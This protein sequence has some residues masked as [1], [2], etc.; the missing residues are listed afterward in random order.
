MINIDY[1][2]GSRMCQSNPTLLQHS[3]V[4]QHSLTVVYVRM[5]VGMYVCVGGCVFVLA[6]VCAGLNEG[7]ICGS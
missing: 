3:Q 2:A 5:C 1:T 4:L 6:R 7:G